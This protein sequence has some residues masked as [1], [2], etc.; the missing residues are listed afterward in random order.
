M[1]LNILEYKRNKLCIAYGL[2][3]VPSTPCGCEAFSMPGAL[4]RIKITWALSRT[5]PQVLGVIR[6]SRLCPWRFGQSSWR[7]AQ[8]SPPVNEVNALINYTR[9]CTPIFK[10]PSSM[11][12]HCF[13][14]RVQPP[15]CIFKFGLI[16][17]VLFLGGPLTTL[18]LSSKNLTYTRP[19]YF[20]THLGCPSFGASPR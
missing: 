7:G 18:D 3:L 9:S 2:T 6:R 13:Y 17:K 19:T 1:I 15:Q 12:R 4:N 8:Y 10:L 5:A 11:V 16:P 20:G 14:L